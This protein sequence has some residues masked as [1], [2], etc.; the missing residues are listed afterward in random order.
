MP[1]DPDLNPEDE[2]LTFS[3]SLDPAALKGLAALLVNAEQLTL[4]TNA[5]LADAVL[6]TLYGAFPVASREM[7][8][9]DELLNRF[10]TLAGIE[11]DDDGEIYYDGHGGTGQTPEADADRG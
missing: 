11:R 3:A 6:E 2:S 1:L 9:L 4:L 10:E 5:D 7:A 8:V